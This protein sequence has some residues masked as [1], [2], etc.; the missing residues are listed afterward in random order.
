M[1]IKITDTKYF[2]K[3]DDMV[4]T[5]MMRY[6]T[7][8]VLPVARRIFSSLPPDV[9]KLKSDFPVE[10]YYYKTDALRELFILVRNFQ[11]NK[12]VYKHIDASSEDIA[13]LKRL[14]ENDLF[15][16]KARRKY[17]WPDAP[18]QRRWDILTIVMSDPV[19]D[20]G[21]PRPWT[22]DNVLAMLRR[23]R[24]GHANLVE[25]AAQ[26]GDPVLLTA[27]AETNALGR[28]FAWVTG[29][30]GSSPSEFIEYQWLVS[31]EVQELGDRIINAYNTLFG[32]ERILHLSS[33]NMQHQYWP[34]LDVPRVAH[35]GL[36]LL[37][38]ENYFW[39]VDYDG[40]VSDR[41]SIEMIT[42]ESFI[43][44]HRYA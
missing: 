23:E 16:E 9:Q 3:L 12:D 20:D 7:E 26:V 41:Y 4:R 42:T 17:P 40:T 31:K 5:Q 27:A 18:V 38:G 30:M 22:I 19:F 28:M 39:I 43:K 14:Y 15:G 11:Q 6:E 25:L 37:T 36:V 13:F 34:E 24:T 33:N 35:L 29:S 21:T 44:K 1:Q 32:E 8:T 2:V 10:G